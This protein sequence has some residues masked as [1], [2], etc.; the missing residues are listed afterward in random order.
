MQQGGDIAAVIRARAVAGAKHQRRHVL[1]V[2]EPHDE[3]A[4]ALLGQ[5]GLLEPGSDVVQLVG[6]EAL[7]QELV[8][9]HVENLVDPL[10]LFAPFFDKEPPQG[11]RLLV[12]GLQSL[13]AFPRLFLQ[14]R[15]RLRLFVEA[16]VEGQ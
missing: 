5:T 13:E 14:L 1:P 16:D 11:Y 6:E 7:S 10:G 8:E 4:V 12:A 9:V 15:V 2:V 3:G